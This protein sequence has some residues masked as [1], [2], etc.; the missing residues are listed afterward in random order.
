MLCS[1]GVQI[2][3]WLKTF[4]N[5]TQI[6][7]DSLKLLK[8][9]LHWLIYS[10]EY[11]F[12][13][14]RKEQAV[15]ALLLNILTLNYECRKSV[16]WMS[17]TI[18]NRLKLLNPF[19]TNVQLTGFYMRGRLVV[20]GLIL[21]PKCGTDP[22]IIRFGWYCLDVR[23]L[24]YPLLFRIYL[25]FKKVLANAFL[26]CWLVAPRPTFCHYQ[27]NRLKNAECSWKTVLALFLQKF[28]PGDYHEAFFRKKFCKLTMLRQVLFKREYYGDIM[29]WCW[30]CSIDKRPGQF[31]L[32]GH[33][34]PRST[35]ISSH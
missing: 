7:P 15:K 24:L 13:H 16:S 8:N 4:V 17:E 5:L 14:K 30:W 27:R 12:L 33:G 29:K 6:L 28:L 2:Q 1:L 26:I 9:M 35:M 34:S 18:I 25:D 19:T 20:K 31:I 23:F 21:E 32:S 22:L 11:L 3:C 10:F